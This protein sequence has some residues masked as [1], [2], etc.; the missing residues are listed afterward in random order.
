MMSSKSPKKHKNTVFRQL[1][2][3]IPPHLTKQLAAEHGVLSRTFTPWSH[4]VAMIYGQFTHAIGLNDI[5]DSLKFS[6]G[7]LSRIRAA[8]AP[9][10]NTLSN[11]NRKRPPEM[12]EALFW[13]VMKDLMTR[14]PSFGRA[15]FKMPRGFK[16]AIHAIDSSTIALVA[17]SMDWAKHRRRKAAAKLHMRLDLRSFLPS[18]AIVD[19]AKGHDASRARELCAGL[20]EGEIVVADRAYLILEL[21]SDLTERGVFWVTRAKTNLKLR[22]VERRIKKPVGNILRDDLVVLVSK[23]AKSKHPKRMRRVIAIV[24]VDGVM[25]EMTFLTNNLDWSPGSIAE[26]YRCRWAIETFFKEIKQTLQL[27]DFYGHNEN[28]VAW[29]IWSALLTHLLLRYMKFLSKWPHS[30]IR[31]FT[32]T[33]AVLWRRLDLLD[34]L[35]PGASGTAPG[36]LRMRGQPELAYL[37]GFGPSGMGQHSEIPACRNEN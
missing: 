4:V 18:F 1:C 32:S 37:P 12:M 5:C 20:Q 21:F 26:L 14:S 13:R 35:S 29:Q 10:R 17:N 36:G 25:R 28:A 15:A 16:R 2:E 22:C 27:A 9:K 24:E 8:V 6:A 30:F 3:L 31:L 11:A 33:R 7:Y 23:T 19:S 34:L